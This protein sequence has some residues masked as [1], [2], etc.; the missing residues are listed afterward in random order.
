MI[1]SIC[2]FG[3]V[4]SLFVVVAPAQAREW[5]DVSGTVIMEAELFGVGPEQI[6]LKREDGELG[7]IRI[8]DLSEADREYLKSEEA[9]KVHEKNIGAIQKWTTTSGLELTGRIVDYVIRDVTIQQRRGQTYVNDRRLDNLPELYQKLLPEVIKHFDE[10]DVSEPRAMQNWL[11]NLRGRPRTFHVEGVV[12]EMEN[13]DEYGIPF[14]VFKEADRKLLKSGWADWV[15]KQHDAQ[16]RMDH[17]FRLESFAAAHLQNQELQRQ[18]AMIDLNLQAV[19]AG[20]TSIWEVT[21][22]PLPG[23]PHPPIWVLMPGRNST[24]ASAAALMQHPGFV[25]GPVRRVSR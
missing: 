12:M 10:V 11:R 8:A 19:R 7:L 15:A 13:G 14:F 3:L 17:A 21:L 22:Y 2:L 20:L 23:N 1:K 16:L 18:I 25:V 24:Q 4:F 9:Q 5:K 6:V